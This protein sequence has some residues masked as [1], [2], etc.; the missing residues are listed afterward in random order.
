MITI[1]E[2]YKKYIDSS[3]D[4]NDTRKVC[5]PFHH[6]DTP[7]F[8]YNPEK[9]I[10]HC[11]GACNTGGDVVALHKKNK[12]FRTYK[13]AFQDLCTLEQ[14]DFNEEYEERNSN[15]KISEHGERVA[16]NILK[17]EYSL[18]NKNVKETL[19]ILQELSIYK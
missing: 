18:K 8:S 9:N 11:F 16:E 2:Y 10:W 15:V 19:R 4:L 17:L 12:N 3:V 14:L 13:E 7:S 5:C 6:E 1:P